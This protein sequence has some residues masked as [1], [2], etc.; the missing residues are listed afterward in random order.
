MLRSGDFCVHDDDNNDNR[1]DHFTPCACVR[2]KNNLKNKR[3]R[4]GREATWY[5]CLH[6]A[7]SRFS[8]VPGLHIELSRLCS[9]SEC[10]QQADP[11]NMQS[12]SE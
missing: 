12:Y 5:T 9:D 11:S 6:T 2:G 10:Y 8:I 1:T 4:A 3:G 7:E